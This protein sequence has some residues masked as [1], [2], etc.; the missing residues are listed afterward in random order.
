M[1]RTPVDCLEGRVV[2]PFVGMMQSCSEARGL[3]RQDELGECDQSL[4]YTDHG[5]L[6]ANATAGQTAKLLRY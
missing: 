6:M 5:Q 2:G 1:R 3:G 4:Q